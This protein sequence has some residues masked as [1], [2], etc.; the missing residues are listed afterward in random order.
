MS[1]DYLSLK[2][3]FA[4]S[5]T[6]QICHYSIRTKVVVRAAVD[7]KEDRNNTRNIMHEL[8]TL[9]SANTI[10]IPSP[11]HFLLIATGNRSTSLSFGV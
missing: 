6:S 5:L 1:M 2:D 10:H 9:M 7:R 3:L 8:Y 11:L 4:V